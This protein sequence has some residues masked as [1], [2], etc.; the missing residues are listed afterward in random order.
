M[1]HPNRPVPGLPR[2]PPGLAPKQLMKITMDSEGRMFDQSG[3]I[4]EMNKPFE[5]K[6]NKKQ[7]NST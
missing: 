2:P 3:K 4:I 1:N 5:L 6:I 7:T